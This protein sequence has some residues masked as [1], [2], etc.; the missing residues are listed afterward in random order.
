M[1]EQL[2]NDYL[3]GPDL[4]RRVVAGM[5]KE[6]LQARPI[7]GKWSTLEVVCHLADYEPILADRMKRI[8]SHDQPTLL[9]AD[10]NRF[11]EHLYYQDRDIEEEL[12]IIEWTRKQMARILKQ[13]PAEAFQRTGVHSE[14]GPMTLQRLLELSVK[15]IPHHI[16]FI[17]D[18]RAALGLARA[19]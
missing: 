6:Q 17:E 1:I 15:H 7:P 10:E 14:R 8:I 18:K 4:L 12:Q 19:S 16:R 5:S 3:A 9:G 13:L 11:A 2:V